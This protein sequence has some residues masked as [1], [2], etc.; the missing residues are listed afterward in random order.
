MKKALL[1][2]LST[3]GLILTGCQEQRDPGEETISQRFIHK[4]GY[5]VSKSEWESELYP[6][7]VQTNLRNGT[8]IVESF[9]EGVLHGERTKTFP[10][11]QTVRVSEKYDHGVLLSRT[12]YNVRGFPEHEEVFHTPTQTKL[13][14]WYPS[15]T[16]R[17][18]EELNE[19]L[20]VSGQYF[21]TKNELDSTIDNGMGEKT[22]RNSFGDILAKEVYRDFEVTLE[23][24]FHPNQKLHTS[25]PFKHGK[26]HGAKK[27][28]SMAGDPLAVENWKNNLRHGAS[29][30]YQNGNK[31]LE[32][33]YRLGKKSGVERNYIDGEILTEETHWRNDQRHGPSIVYFD[34]VARTS[35]Y[36]RNVKTTQEKYDELVAREAMIAR[37]NQRSK[38]NAL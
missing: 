11:S 13:T 10:H 20:I 27:V 16:P 34:G 5:D 9:E 3:T 4:Y 1:L 35:W 23:E 28:F 24:T 17:S 2:L 32:V 29:T 31:F 15:G 12:N 33:N 25:T 22:I 14:I 37:M 6:G 30:Y 8:T 21:N 19:G 18:I 38:T 7:Q 36:H 26:I